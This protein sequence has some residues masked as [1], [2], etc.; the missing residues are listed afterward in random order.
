MKLAISIDVEEE[1]LF[2]G[3]YPRTP[4]GVANVRELHRLA[5]AW[6]RFG[7]PLT[8]LPTYPVAANAA[9]VAQLRR[10]ADD[11]RAEIGAHLHAWCTPP[12]TEPAG[13]EPLRTDAIP[14]AALRAKMEILC[15][16]IE[17]RFGAPPRSFRA[18]RFDLG[19]QLLKLLPE[20]RISV[21]SS[22]VPLRRVPDGPADHFSAPTE[23]FWQPQAGSNAP[24]LEVPLTMQAVWPAAATAV[25]RLAPRLPGP[26]RD[27]LFAAVRYVGSAGIHPVWFPLPSMKLAARL[28][29]RRG[30]SVLNMFFHSSELCPGATPA[31]PAEE[32]VQRLVRKI[33]HFLEWLETQGPLEGVTLSQLIP[34]GRPLNAPCA[35]PRR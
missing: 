24:F 23:P 1:G 3:R 31:C 32:S 20:F 6:D 25:G 26:L 12:F 7:I 30:G 34:A 5:F 28:H 33:R 4:P 15:S 27:K 18:G 22:V 16:T 10:L 13:P 11:K 21:D 17:N 19:C 8:L 2:C 35:T 29:Q 14:L 9:C